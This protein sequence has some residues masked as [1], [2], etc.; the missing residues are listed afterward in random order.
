M[1]NLWRTQDA[2]ALVARYGARDV[3]RDVAECL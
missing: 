2:E 1:R 3:G